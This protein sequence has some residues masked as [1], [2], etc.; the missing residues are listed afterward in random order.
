MKPFLKQT[1]RIPLILVLIAMLAGTLQAFAAGVDWTRKFPATQPSGRF[2]HAMANIDG[3]QVLL[4]GGRHTTSGNFDETW[5]YDLSAN[6]WAQQIPS[7][8]PSARY[9]SA[10]AKIGGD[11]VLLFGGYDSTFDNET[12]VYDLSD[13]TWTNKSPISKPSARYLHSMANIGGDQVLLFGGHDGA[14]DNETWVYDLSDNSWTQQSPVSQ[15]SGRYN[16]TIAAFG[17]GGDQVVLFGGYDGASDNETWVYD[18]SDDNWTLQSPTSQPSARTKHAM[19]AFVVGGD[20]VLL[21]GGLV[22]SSN[23]NETWV[24][25]LS[26]DNWTLQSPVSKPSSRGDHALADI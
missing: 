7:S 17:L 13:N 9:G 18:L 6:T 23:N 19:A 15:P 21:F 1:L 25:D 2:L 24:Y 8:Q 16:H 11:Q 12:W 10:M 14:H 20:Q 5:V 22:G 3:D 26:D 4:F